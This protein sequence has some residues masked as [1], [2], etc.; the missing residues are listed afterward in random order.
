M[1]N[2]VTGNTIDRGTM[3]KRGWSI[4]SEVSEPG[5]EK[6]EDLNDDEKKALLD[7]FPTLPDD[8]DNATPSPASRKRIKIMDTISTTR[9]RTPTSIQPA[10]GNGGKQLQLEAAKSKLSKWAARLFDPNRPRGLVEAP[11]VIPLNDEF[12]QA[13]GKRE[14]E[15]DTALGRTI[16]I[17]T[18]NLDEDQPSDDDDDDDDGTFEADPQ[19]TEKQGCKIKISNLLFTTTE[20]TLRQACSVYGPLADVNLLMDKDSLTTDNPRNMGIAYVTFESSKCAD[21][22]LQQLTTLQGR[23]L[24]LGMAE[25]LPRKTRKS[26][27]SGGARYWDVDIS[28]KCFRCGQVGHLAMKCPNEAKPTP[29]ALCG[30][31]GHDIRD[32][33][34]GR[35]CFKCGTPGHINRDCKERY[36]IKRMVCGTCFESGH[37]RVRCKRDLSYA[38]S[39]EAVCMVC[40]EKGHF[41]CQEM[42]WFFG[43]K[44]ITCFNCGRLDHHGY[45]CDRPRFEELTRDDELIRNEIDRAEATSL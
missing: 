42:K 18:T 44:G 43:L 32:C 22:C 9:T 35:T 4:H 3:R 33:R 8:V 6:E 7:S 40:H 37:H 14:K 21:A 27:G 20:I 36:P 31:T 39:Q 29:C 5:N 12:L 34:L 45:D 15:F 16:A 24:R 13:F 19:T 30:D 41:M 10:G 2:M 25:D 1:E 11:Q 26:L 17:D 28:T 23:P 38:S